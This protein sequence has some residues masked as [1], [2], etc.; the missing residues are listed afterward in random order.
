MIK[1]E[2]ILFLVS[3]VSLI[4]IPFLFVHEVRAEE[5]EIK[6]Y[7]LEESVSE[8]LKN[9]WG[10]KAQ[11]ERIQESEFV[12]KQAR[13]DFL[14][15]VSTTYGY[16]RLSEV[17]RTL[18][19]SLGGAIIPGREL[20]AQD[21]YRWTGTI[22]QPLFTG[23]ALKSTYELAK[24]GI[25][26][27][28]VNLDLE[29]L[30]LALRV[31]EAYFNILGADKSVQV[32]RS[33]VESLESHLKVARNFYEVGMIP[34]NDLLEA[35][36]ELGN[37]QH[38]L[39]IAENASRLARATFN[40]HLSRPVNSPVEVKDMLEYEPEFPDFDRYLERA[41][42]NRPELKALDIN[43]IQIDQQTVL[44]KSRYYPELALNY[45]YIKEG[46]SPEVDGSAFHDASSWQVTLG[47]SWTLWNWGKTLYSVRENE[48]RKRQ[49]IQTRKT[50]EDVIKLE[51]RNALLDLDEAAKNIPTTEKAVEQAEENLRVSEER[52]KAQV[53]TS[54]EVLDA[55]T[56]LTRA[57]VNYYN[58]IYGHRLAK[59]AL[60]RAIGE[61]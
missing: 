38:N 60:L 2:K 9:N 30:D 25:D 10:I 44:A 19:Q 6:V 61:Y 35:E 16:T 22:S 26:L 34:I 1:S 47:L 14:P 42:Q 12:K 58:A 32:A 24:L 27:S 4:I 40:T 43:S 31:K 55:Q 36:V 8:A 28:K 41:L 49:L 52:Y 50:L 57:R 45:S 7:T 37:A 3:L 11:E 33:A 53:T 29:M 46:D 54:T 15:T 17:Q 23:F 18:P 13:S 51:L 5:D 21:N 39:T 48:S 56:L 59:A 20:N